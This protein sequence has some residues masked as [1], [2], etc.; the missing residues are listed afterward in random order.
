MDLDGGNLRQVTRF[1]ND[2]NVF[3]HNAAVSA[4]GSTIVFE[5]NYDP[6]TKAPGTYQIWTVR[7]DGGGLRRLTAGKAAANPSVSADGGTVVYQQ[8][9][10][11]YALRG[12]VTTALTSFSAGSA[13][14]PAVSGNATRVALVAGPA[15]GGR[16]SIWSVG[17]DG[18]SLQPVWLPRSIS[19]NGVAGMTPGIAPSP[20][21]L[22]SVYGYNFCD[23]GVEAAAGF[24]LPRT[25]RG[26][27]LLVSGK[28]V[29]LLAV[30]PWQINA[31]LPLDT[32]P[33]DSP[34]QVRFT[35]GST[36]PAVTA[37]VKR[38]APSVFILPGTADR[39]PLAA[40]FHAGTAIPADAGHPASAGEVLEIYGTGFGMTDPPVAAGD[41]APSPPARLS[42]GIQ[43]LIGRQPASILFAGL[44]P[45]L[46]GVYQVNAVMPTG[47]AAGEHA[48]TWVAGSDSS[49]YGWLSLR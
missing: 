47:L 31:Q 44:V 18:T 35:D 16:A 25:L 27:M 21:G 9:G 20:G 2:A 17:T 39:S 42:G 5:S 48:M 33:G 43:L 1:G 34:F 45:G 38:V 24:P 14:E 26:V 30:T 7:A 40:A 29:P 6:D 41:A 12:T 46:A 19:P 36:T 22:F 28:P 32:A 11:V 4:D 15:S 3:A 8:G 23:D 49:T 13:Q 37:E 10:Q